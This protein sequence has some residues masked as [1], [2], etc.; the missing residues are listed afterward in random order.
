VS[1]HVVKVR[2]STLTAVMWSS[3]DSIG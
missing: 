2:N 3:G 1:E